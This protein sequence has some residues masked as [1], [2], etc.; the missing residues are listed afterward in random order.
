MKEI[1]RK[2][3]VE[4][5]EEMKKL[6]ILKDNEKVLDSYTYYDPEL[7]GQFI[8]V[9]T[10]EE[11]HVYY[12]TTYFYSVVTEEYRFVNVNGTM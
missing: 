3:N 12:K 11:D 1:T 5:V 10:V 2:T 8:T 6:N 4:M 7:E 9:I